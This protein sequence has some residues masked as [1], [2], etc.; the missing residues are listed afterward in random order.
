MKL[1]NVTRVSAVGKIVSEEYI[2]TEGST[3]V[4]DG[5]RG[6]YETSLMEQRDRRDNTKTGSL[7]RLAT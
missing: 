4:L 2:A 3:E 6:R 1:R 5:A 7:L